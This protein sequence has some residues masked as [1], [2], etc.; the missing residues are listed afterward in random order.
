MRMAS[1]S[2]PAAATL[3]LQHCCCHAPCSSMPAADSCYRSL[4][5]PRAAAT[6]LLPSYTTT[7]WRC[8]TV[9]RLRL[10]QYLKQH[11][12]KPAVIIPAVQRSPITK[13]K[14]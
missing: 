7:H 14:N 4:L 12:I 10:E 11:I 13:L 2:T 1:Y 3:L 5:Q 6:L 9:G 8:R